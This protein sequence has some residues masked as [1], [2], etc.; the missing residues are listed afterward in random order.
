MTLEEIPEDVIVAA[1][2]LTAYFESR[3]IDTWELGGVCSRDHAFAISG[4]Y[5]QLKEVN[6]GIKAAQQTTE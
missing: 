1:K 2:T 4:I 6:D 5:T 3:N